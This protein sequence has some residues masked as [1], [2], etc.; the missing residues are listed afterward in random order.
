MGETQI[1]PFGIST[2]PFPPRLS[3]CSRPGLF[4][5]PSYPKHGNA[6]RRTDL[7]CHP[8]VCTPTP[9]NPPALCFS[10]F[11]L[12]KPQPSSASLLF[13]PRC[14]RRTAPERRRGLGKC[15][16]SL[17]RVTSPAV[18]S[19]SQRLRFCLWSQKAAHEDASDGFCPLFHSPA[20]IPLCSIRHQGRFLTSMLFRQWCHSHGDVVL[21]LRQS[22]TGREKT[23]DL[24][25]VKSGS[26][27]QNIMTVD[28]YIINCVVEPFSSAISEVSVVK[29]WH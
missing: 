22:C 29:P 27:V 12:I 15:P 2:F 6:P 5:F 17:S 24:D 28:G 7:A 19:L 13:L 21:C 8:D 14:A 26:H 1:F 11:S 25:V 4:I 18:V 3:L 16:V 20:F 9:L 23:Q 10:L